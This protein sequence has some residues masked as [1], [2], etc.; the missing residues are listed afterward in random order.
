MLKLPD[1]AVCGELAMVVFNEVRL[2]DLMEKPLLRSTDVP[3]VWRE[4][5]NE[6]ELVLEIVGVC[7]VMDQCRRLLVRMGTESATSSLFPLLRVEFPLGVRA[8]AE[9]SCPRFGWYF[10]WSRCSR[11]LA[12][13][14]GFLL[15][16]SFENKAW[17]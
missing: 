12:F 9:A 13:P 1:L 7:E 3:A 16:L 4:C 2:A 11:V 17:V 6:L 10:T 14:S 15:P 8:C 5:A